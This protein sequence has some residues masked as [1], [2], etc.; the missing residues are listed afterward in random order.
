MTRSTFD[1]RSQY[2]I[3]S[4]DGRNIVFQTAEAG[5]SV[6][7][8]DGAGKPQP[9]TESRNIQFPWSFTADGKR[10]AFQEQDSKTGRDLWTVPME[11]DGAGLR[12]GKPELSLQTPADERD[13]ALS[14][15]G[16]L[17]AYASN[18]SKSVGK[19]DAGKS[20]RPV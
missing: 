17:L 20:A 11:S 18:E 6:T 5:T 4:P 13:P 2:P 10:M 3:W 14:P 12:A 1:G 8:S 7:R 19:P 16:R 15:D 9:L